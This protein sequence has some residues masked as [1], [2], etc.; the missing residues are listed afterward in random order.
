VEFLDY[1]LS[2]LVNA[3]SNFAANRFLVANLDDIAPLI[4]AGG[5]GVP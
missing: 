5:T 1:S 4:A 3:G 2:G